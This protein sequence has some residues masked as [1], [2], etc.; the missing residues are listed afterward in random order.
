MAR[1]KFSATDILHGMVL[2]LRNGSITRPMV[3][4]QAVNYAH[5]E[6]ME[7]VGRAIVAA[8]TRNAVDKWLERVNRTEREVQY[9][10]DDAVIKQSFGW[11]RKLRQQT[12]NIIVEPKHGNTTEHL[13]VV[14]LMDG[15]CIHEAWADD[16]K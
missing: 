12:V 6:R 1:R 15:T 10:T 8:A 13:H 11:S 16:H 7:K 14:F 4:I 5:D 2:S 9:E 3:T